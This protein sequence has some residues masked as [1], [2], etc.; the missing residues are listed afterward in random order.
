M[1]QISKNNRDQLQMLSISE[2]VAEVSLARV[3]DV[4]IDSADLSSLGF[5]LKG[6]FRT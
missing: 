4:F 3:I 2:H 1:P 6:N 5:Q